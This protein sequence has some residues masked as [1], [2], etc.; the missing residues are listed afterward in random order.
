MFVYT[1]CVKVLRFSVLCI[2]Y[3][4]W[5]SIIELKL[6]EEKFKVTYYIN[7]NKLMIK[8]C[9]YLLCKSVKI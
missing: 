5:K 1:C 7:T 4:V 3:P 9:I 2:L 8:V 6:V